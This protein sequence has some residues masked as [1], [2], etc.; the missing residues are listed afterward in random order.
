MGMTLTASE[1]RVDKKCGQSGI[2]DNAKCTKRTAPSSSSSGSGQ[3]RSVVSRIGRKLTGAE[4]RERKKAAFEKEHQAR[5][6]K[7][8]KNSPEAWGGE[9][10]APNSAMGKYLKTIGKD[11]S[12]IGA[13][14]PYAQETSKLIDENGNLIKKSKRDSIWAEGF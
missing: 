7:H 5:M 14:S 13:N 3:K 6:S 9:S 10:V 11:P 2:P 8:G 4:G 12:K 1:F